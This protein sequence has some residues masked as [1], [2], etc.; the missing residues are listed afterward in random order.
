MEATPA[1]TVPTAEEIA[2]RARVIERFGEKRIAELERA[3][4]QLTTIEVEDK[5]GIFKS[6]DRK[7]LSMATT[8]SRDEPIE[9]LSLI[10]ENCFVEGDKILLE[11][12]DYFFSIMPHLNNLSNLK[13]AKLLKM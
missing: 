11:N 4:G 2:L 7:I 9:Y 3:H 10:A 12:D 5:M 8:A 13:V 6:P 1:T